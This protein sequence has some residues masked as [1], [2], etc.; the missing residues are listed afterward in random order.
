MRFG[1]LKSQK[2]ALYALVK[3]VLRMEVKNRIRNQV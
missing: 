1:L 2:S 3:D